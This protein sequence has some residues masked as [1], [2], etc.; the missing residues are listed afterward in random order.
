M[1]TKKKAQCNTKNLQRLEEVLVELKINY[2]IAKDGYL[3]LTDE[4]ILIDEFEILVKHLDKIG[5]FQLVGI[6]DQGELK[7]IHDNY[8]IFRQCNSCKK[9]Y[10]DYFQREECFYCKSSHLFKIESDKKIPEWNPLPP[11][12]I[13]DPNHKID[14]EMKIG[15]EDKQKLKS[16]IIKKLS[17]EA[18]YITISK[19]QIF[20]LRELEH[21]YPNMVAFFKYL[22]E[23]IE[24]SKMKIHGELSLKPSVLVGNAGC[25]K[26]SC[27]VELSR[28]LQG[29]PAIRI[30]LGNDIAI[31]TCTGSDPS[32][33][34]AKHG[35][36]IESMFAEEDGHPIK[37]PI[38]HFDEL[39][40]IK[41]KREHSI[42]PLFYSI[43]EKS[44]SKHFTDNFLGVE[45]DASGINYIFTANSLD[46]IPKPILNRLRIFEI[47]DYT[48]EQFRTVVIDSFY[49]NWLNHNNLKREFFPEVL[50]DEIKNEIIKHS[51]CDPRSINDAFTK[52]F[53]ETM[54]IDD[55]TGEKIA[56]FSE[57]ELCSGWQKYR[58]KSKYSLPKW[59][60]PKPFDP[61]EF[62]ESYLS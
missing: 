7:D 42:E 37:N 58:G 17:G 21:K 20:E 45:T 41:T 48:E 19:E 23:Q 22:Y 59:K 35:L 8:F 18:K 33:I 43:L 5:K 12:F 1:T 2:K 26:T 47:P 44:T 60:L 13:L 4:N 6:T 57:P 34:D 39:D 15:N 16:Q 30:D 28:I 61:V 3:I 49:E 27:V 29:K 51:N 50:S 36:I 32:Y 56:L 55:E 54:R 14:D 62:L 38:V 52:I 31:F 24:L 10:L 25:G 40:K 53:T 11:E 46:S 9:F